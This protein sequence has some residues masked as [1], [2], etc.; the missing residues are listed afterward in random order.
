MLE[1]CDQ[2]ASS[3]K[4]LLGDH[5]RFRVDQIKFDLH[6][7]GYL[8]ST[9]KVVTVVDTTHDKKYT[10]TIEAEKNVGGSRESL[11]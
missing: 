1:Y 5:T 8:L 10:I 7:E 11:S 6:E 9:K 3:I 2:I 4:I